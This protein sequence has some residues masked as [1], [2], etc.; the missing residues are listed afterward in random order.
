MQVRFK[1]TVSLYS[2]V[3]PFSDGY[4]I[5]IYRKQNRLSTTFDSAKS[6][7]VF[8]Q[9][10]FRIALSTT[11]ATLLIE[12]SSKKAVLSETISIF[13]GNSWKIHRSQMDLNPGKYTISISTNENY[14]YIREIKIT[15]NEGLNVRKDPKSFFLSFDPY[16]AGFCQFVDPERNFG[17][18]WIFKC[19]TLAKLRHIR[20]K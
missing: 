10:D 16:I 11:S 13:K 1:E 9:V 6:Q 17:P 8:I 4:L 3:F 15:T 19:P 7:R 2:K 5:S 14:F 18:V 12:D 20:R